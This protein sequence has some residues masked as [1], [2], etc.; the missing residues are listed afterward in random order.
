M[1]QDGY[2]NIAFIGQGPVGRVFRAVRTDNQE[3]VRLKLISGLPDLLPEHRDLVKR[4]FFERCLSSRALDEIHYAVTVQAGLTD[5]GFFIET[6][7]LHARPML[8]FLSDQPRLIQDHLIEVFLKIVRV[9]EHLSSARFVHGNIRVTNVLLTP[10]LEPILTDAEMTALYDFML[11]KGYGDIRDTR[12]LS[13]EQLA[14]QPTTPPDDIFTVCVLMYRALVDRYP[15]GEQVHFLPGQL[16]FNPPTKLKINLS[17]CY[18]DFFTKA[19]ALEPADRFTTYP[20][21][22][23]ALQNLDR[24]SSINHTI[25]KPVIDTDHCDDE[26]DE[27]IE[28]LLAQEYGSRKHWPMK[29]IYTVLG[30]LALAFVSFWIMPSTLKDY[31]FKP[32]P[33]KI[34]TIPSKYGPEQHRGPVEPKQQQSRSH[35]K[36][37]LDLSFTAQEAAF[38][39]FENASYRGTTPLAFDTLPPGTY[40][41]RVHAPGFITREITI[42]PNQTGTQRI[43][44]EADRNTIRYPQGQ[45]PSRPCYGFDAQHSNYCAQSIAF[46]LSVLWK[47]SI[48]AGTVSPVSIHQGQIFLTSPQSYLTVLDLK[49]GQERG[50]VILDQGALTTPLLTDEYVIITG[51]DGKI[52][53]F[54]LNKLKERGCE[55]T[56]SS[57]SASPVLGGNTIVTASMIGS[58]MALGFEQKILKKV[59]F[60]RRWLF[61]SGQRITSSPALFEDTLAIVQGE[62]SVFAL[63]LNNGQLIWQFIFRDD[64]TQFG[65]DSTIRLVG[66]DTNGPSPCVCGSTVLAVTSNGSVF[67]LEAQT[68]TQIWV[69]DLQ[70]EIYASPACYHGLVFVVSA[71]GM[72]AALDATNGL[73]LYTLQLDEPV[74]ATPLVAGSD[75]I[76]ITES[77]KLSSFYALTGQKNGEI[78]LPGHYRISPVL[79]ERTLVI[80]SNDGFIMAL[81]EEECP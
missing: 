79:A 54:D 17:E 76:I 60:I 52:R 62:N 46:P 19:F 10:E 53:A 61:D 51:K 31:I 55:S 45:G 78:S 77:G 80:P 12:Y 14:G 11:Q 13:P 20:D 68:G 59:H 57:F 3:V 24:K 42:Q 50:S 48:T 40:T 28:E 7:E 72:V 37:Q 44:L 29:L 43:E 33:D 26:L 64:T 34:I 41:Y 36:T 18:D 23:E 47:A 6:K 1:K 16:N 21:L 73:L 70:T 81:H 75:L 38:N 5:L 49:T 4:L 39:V 71:H 58:V 25:P 2:H 15:F 27:S 67:G 9:L 22:A 8:E 65:L 63:D 69:H 74:Y 35:S 66:D 32:G 56:Q 30:I